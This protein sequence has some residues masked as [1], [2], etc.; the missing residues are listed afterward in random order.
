MSEKTV[1][2]RLVALETTAFRAE[3]KLLEEKGIRT[4]NIGSG[5]FRP[6][7]EIDSIVGMRFDPTDN[8]KVQIWFKTTEETGVHV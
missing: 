8:T 4:Y 1:E 6:I 5:G 2:E 7:P 3:R